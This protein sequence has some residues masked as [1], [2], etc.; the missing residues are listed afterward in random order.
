MGR[1][2]L[3]PTRLR[4][5]PEIAGYRSSL[6]LLPDLGERNRW[7]YH[8]DSGLVV[9]VPRFD[10]NNAIIRQLSC[11]LDSL[12]NVRGPTIKEG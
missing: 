9:S 10:R 12:L 8:L 1:G 4:C 2:G 6:Y 11:T 3:L 5:S 7:N